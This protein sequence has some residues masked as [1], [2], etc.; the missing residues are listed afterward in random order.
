MQ[1]HSQDENK[2]L[3]TLQPTSGAGL[4]KAAEVISA[5]M[6]QGL[7]AKQVSE[8]FEIPF[9][10]V[11]E[12]LGNP[13]YLRHFSSIRKEAA[14]AEFHAV[15]HDEMAGVVKNGKPL[16]KVAAANAWAGILG[17]KDHGKITHEH[18]WVEDTIRSLKKEG[19]VID[20][21]VEDIDDD[22]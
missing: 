5:M 22:V 12:L 1:D 13:T 4:V 21:E 14:R 16:E 9:L 11:V 15:V 7:T 18:S 6:T 2:A 17:E 20:A 19:H 8:Q 10:D 3:I